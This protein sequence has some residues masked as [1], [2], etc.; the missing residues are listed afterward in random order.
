MER[1]APPMVPKTQGLIS[2]IMPPEMEQAV[3][4]LSRERKKEI[5]DLVRQL[6]AVGLKQQGIQPG[7]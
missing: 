4:R 7:A 5:H 6:R 2:L 1:N 3:Q